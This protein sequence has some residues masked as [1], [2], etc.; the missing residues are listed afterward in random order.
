GKAMTASFA[1]LYR[2]EDGK[3]MTMEQYVDS[4]LVMSA[5]A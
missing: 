5:L 3:I 2:L 4:A 1:H